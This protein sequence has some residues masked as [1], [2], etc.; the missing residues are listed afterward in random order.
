MFCI[1]KKYDKAFKIAAV[2]QVLQEGKQV[3]QVAKAIGIIPTML[4]WWVYEY[5]AN[6][7]SAFSGSGI[8]SLIRM[9]R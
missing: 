8:Q 6:P 9:S 4:S 3:T 5:Q 1:R 7:D 2:M